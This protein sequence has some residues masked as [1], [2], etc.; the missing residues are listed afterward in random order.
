MFFL[1]ADQ[2]KTFWF[3]EQASTFAPEVD[4]FF[5]AVTYI[6]LAFF[7][8]IVGF[9]VYFMY[10][11]RERPGYKGSPEAL[12]NNALEIGW[13]VVPTIIAVWI[14]YRGTIGFLDMMT[15][16][17]DTRDV[18]VV[19]KKW[20]WSFGY[21]NGVVDNEL[22]LVVNEPAKMIM[23][24]DDVLH[25]LFVPAFR[26]K[27][28]VVPGRYA[29]MWFEPTK[30]GTYDLFCSEYCGDQHSKMGAKV[31]V[32]TKEEYDAWFTKMQIPPSDPVE[33]GKL[34]YAKTMGCASCHSV[35]GKKI[36]GP[37]FKGTWG[38][39]VTLAGG[40]TV[41]FDENYV[42]ESV[43]NPQAKYRSGYEKASLMPSY[44]GRLKE[45]QIS[46]LIAYMKSLKSE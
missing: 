32:H 39:E 44:Q 40:G 7:V 28:D 35:D 3:P 13:T 31:V 45:E 23:R 2:N 11:Y 30:T 20:A 14:F 26:A 41:P 17:A 34:L 33:Y 24:S 10:A 38:G 4:W 22:H 25:S 18:Q 43:L 37:S 5:L 21:P 46:A 15:I 19:A 9:M 12:H 36:V 1:L 27:C 29:T 16:P 8:L 6:S 42:R